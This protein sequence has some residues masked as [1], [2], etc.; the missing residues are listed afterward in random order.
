MFF[1]VERGSVS[2]LSRLTGYE[3]FN[4]ISGDCSARCIGIFLG[5]VLAHLAHTKVFMG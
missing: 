3:I 1:W 4:I 5:D 2:E